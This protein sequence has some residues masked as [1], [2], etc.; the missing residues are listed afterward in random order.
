M[1]DKIIATIRSRDDFA[2]TSHVR[3]DGDALGSEL[4][5]MLA[6][7]A[8][9]KSAVVINRDPVP[10]RYRS[11]PES[12]RILVSDHIEANR[13]AVFVLECGSEDRTGIR[14]LD[15]QFVINI[16]HHHSTKEFASLN[17][18]D[19]SACAVG[20]MV[21]RVIQTLGVKITPA[22]ATNIYTAV[23]TD[24]GSFQFASTT[25]DTFR[26]AATLA[27]AGANIAGIARNV[28]YSNPITKVNS[29]MVMLNHMKLDCD[30]KLVW[31]AITRSDMAQHDCLE[32][33]VEGLV[34]FPLTISGVDVAVFFR[35]LEDGTYRVSL[36]S[37]DSI[38]VSEIAGE[39]GGGGHRNAS[40]CTLDGPLEAARNR[41]LARVA[42]RMD[43]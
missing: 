24:T 10:E 19:P 32:D 11:L 25:A 30:G 26:M 20:E 29:M 23:V 18:I 27:D 34:N 40:G 15:G 22:I 35:E 12:H 39:F 8:L 7:E 28:F 4:A 38:D 16:D 33:D 5:L 43:A 2:I 41:L 6:L 14:G 42:S 37:K 21:Y 13:G 31:T 17:W 36:R 3:P 1:L 9:G